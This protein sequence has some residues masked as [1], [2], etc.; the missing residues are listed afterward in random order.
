MLAFYLFCLIVGG[1]LLSLSLFAD[2]LEAEVEVDTQGLNLLS[3]RS[4]IYFLFTFGGVGAVLTWAWGS[5]GYLFTLVAAALA[6]VTVAGLA[7]VV[8]RYLRRTD[9]GL[10]DSAE[11]GFI[12][13]PARV[14]VPVSHEGPGKVIVERSGRSFE[15]LA[16][17]HA[18]DA[19]EPRA[20]GAVVVV[21]MR[22]GVALV[23][24]VDA[25]L[26]LGSPD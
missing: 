3:L 13:L 10:R 15:L 5:G 8:F 19:P 1:G 14:S 18:E 20:W 11:S 12:G 23:A 24:P 25:T 22:N 21:E 17:P 4:A 7:S 6:G 16:R 26:R 2:V 9:S